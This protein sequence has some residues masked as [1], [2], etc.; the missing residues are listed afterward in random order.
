M[1]LII[2][3]K[4]V[5]SSGRQQWKLEGNRLKCYLKSAPQQGKANNELIRIIAHALQLPSSA[6]LLL[7]GATTRIKR[8]KIEGTVTFGAL[9]K[10]LGIDQQ[11]SLF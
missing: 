1:A 3:I 7:S 6:I 8:I 5:P 9:L 10:A 2:D 4:V 11:T